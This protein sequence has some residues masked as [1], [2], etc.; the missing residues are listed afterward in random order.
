MP[1]LIENGNLF[2]AQPPLFKV[3]KGKTYSY[4]RDENMLNETVK[5]INGEVIIQRFKGLGEMDTNELH[6]T[7]MDID[8][9]I[10]KQITIEDAVEADKTFSMLMG[11]EV[12]PRREFIQ[13]N[14]HIAEIDI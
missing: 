8:K 3:I 6:E 10:L 13:K 2:I 14:A 7:V 4:A 9:R 11:D 5:Q 1:I 12:G